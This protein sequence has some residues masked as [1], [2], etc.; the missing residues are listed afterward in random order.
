MLDYSEDQRQRAR[1]AIALFREGDSRRARLGA[2]RVRRTALPGPATVRPLA[3]YFFVSPLGLSANGGEAPSSQAASRMW[4]PVRR[5][6]QNNTGTRPFDRTTAELL[7]VRAEAQRNPT[8]RSG[9]VLDLPGR[10]GVRAPRPAHASYQRGGKAREPQ[11]ISA[12]H[13]LVFGQPRQ[14]E[15]LTLLRDLPLEIRSRL[16]DEVENRSVTVQSPSRA[17][18]E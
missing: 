9:A 8:R 10:S 6:W 13:P 4:Y 7:I 5:T 16:A 15:L 3:R 11:A 12:I 17:I 2:G 14:G 1:E 18:G